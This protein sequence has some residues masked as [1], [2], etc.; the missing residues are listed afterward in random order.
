MSQGGEYYTAKYAAA[1][2]AI[3]WEKRRP[4]VVV[5]WAGFLP[6]LVAVDVS[7]NVLVA[8]PALHQ[9]G[10]SDSYI[11]KYA[12]QNGALLWQN[13][14]DSP[15]DYDWLNSLAVDGGGN[16]FVAGVSE[17][18]NDSRDYY[19]VTVA[20]ANTTAATTPSGGH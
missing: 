19:A 1:D 11:A 15:S 13:R 3:L 20:Q 7:G 4:R 16:V 5:S 9:D 6:A 2:G 17:G 18:N 8:M 12:E 14:F 10:I